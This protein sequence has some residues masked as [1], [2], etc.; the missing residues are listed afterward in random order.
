MKSFFSI[1]LI[2]LFISCN[3]SDDDT[4]KSLGQTEEDI[5]AYIAANNLTAERSETGLYYIVEEEGDGDFVD[6]K[7]T[8]N[9]KYTGY[10]LDGTV[11]D[12]SDS[13]GYTFQLVNLIRGFSE[14][15]TN[16]KKGGK[17]KILIPPSLG[18]GSYGSNIIPGDAVLIFDIEILNVYNP[19]TEDNIIAYLAENNLVAE[20]NGEGVYYIVENEGDGDPINENSVVTIN[21]TGYLLDG[22]EFEK[23]PDGGST[24]Y[25]ANTISGFSEGIS[26]FNVGGKGTIFIVPELAYGENG[27][28]NTIPP[29]TVVAFD[30]EVLSKN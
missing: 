25:L 17:G 28:S 19:Q 23:S 3:S 16:F 10:F 13:E 7:A 24:L 2:T 6:I 15:L 26:F 1:L 22:T 5:V 27:Y 20:D 14:G 21:Y 4:L 12:S 8:V 29:N 18:Y 11:F 9:V 30:I